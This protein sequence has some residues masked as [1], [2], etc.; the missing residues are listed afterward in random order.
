MS[1]R[2]VKARSYDNSR[3]AEQARATRARVVE[4]AR[5]LLL[6]QGYAATTIAQ[7]ARTA[8]VSAE[9]VQKGF[10]TKAAL[11]K[12]VYDV[13]LVG[14][15]EPVPLRDRPEF[16]A[17]IAEADPVRKLAAYAAVGRGLWERLG[18][19]LAV[20]VQ[21]AQAGEPDLVEF[22][23]T[24]RRESYAGASGLVADLAE[25][26]ALRPGLPVEQARDELW[27]LIQPELWLLLGERGWS[28]DAVQAWFTRTASAA[29]LA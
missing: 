24:V 20:L 27:L 7:I 12:A 14:D 11:A 1:A 3:R 29:L 26:G 23:A 15:D 13:T 21:G 28:L 8:G 6:A 16:Q 10:G 2:D 9:T 19:L 17:V 22:V 4:A 5:G 18:P 25:R